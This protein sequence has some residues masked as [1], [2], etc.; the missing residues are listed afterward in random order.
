[1]FTCG[2]PLNED[3]PTETLVAAAAHATAGQTENAVVEATDSQCVAAEARASVGQTENTVVQN[4]SVDTAQNNPEQMDDQ[5]DVIETSVVEEGDAT[6]PSQ[7]ILRSIEPS[8]SGSVAPLALTAL[9]PLS[10]GSRELRTKAKRVVTD[11]LHMNRPSPVSTTRSSTPGSQLSQRSGHS[12]LPVV[13]PNRP[14]PG[15]PRAKKT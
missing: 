11:L 5:N 7:S 4:A 1:M 13:T 14:P 9:A 12:L 10:Y 8:A 3:T 2:Q 6:P 15:R